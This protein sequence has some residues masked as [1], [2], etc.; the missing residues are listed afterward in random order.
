MLHDGKPLLVSSITC[1]HVAL[2]NGHLVVITSMY[3]CLSHVEV[4][5]V[6]LQWSK[7]GRKEVIF[8]QYDPS[9]GQ[10]IAGEIKY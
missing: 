7:L 5:L 3:F 1:L 10:K 8:F 6:P 4:L 2:K 9:I